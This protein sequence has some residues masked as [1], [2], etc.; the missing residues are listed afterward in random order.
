MFGNLTKFIN[1]YRTSDKT[2]YNWQSLHGGKF[3]IPPDKKNEFKKCFIDAHPHFSDKDYVSL[4]WKCRDKQIP[5]H[6]DFDIIT[7]ECTIIPD[8]V[9]INIAEEISDIVSYEVRMGNFNVILERK[10]KPYPRKFE[11]E[12][13]TIDAWKTGFHA[14]FIGFLVPE[15]TAKRIRE[16]SLCLFGELATKYNIINK[17]EDIYDQSI[18]PIGSNGVLLTGCRKPKRGGN[19]D[20]YSFFFSATFNYND[21]WTN[22]E[23]HKPCDTTKLIEK[24]FDDLWGFVWT[25]PDWK[26]IPLLGGPV[27][28][29]T[30][31]VDVAHG[32]MMGLY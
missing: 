15:E 30:S 13:N 2:R 7:R 1:Q 26:T 29:P 14:L 24:H 32:K 5:L 18:R 27:E 31:R 21:T 10:Q 12:G 16:K 20:V 11:Y 3:Y 28:A 4:V 17:I 22:I 23:H 9:F 19:T 6:L 25:Q 8:E